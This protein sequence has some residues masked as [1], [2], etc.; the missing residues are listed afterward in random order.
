M[1]EIQRLEALRKTA[2]LDTAPEERFDRLTRLASTALGADIALVSFID[3]DRQ[4]FKSKQGTENQET[5]RD[6]A[7]CNHAIQSKD[8]MVVADA[9]K[10]SRFVNNPLVAGE[11]NIRF[12]AGAP[13]VTKDGHAL[14]TLC[15]LDDKPRADF[16]PK[17][18]QILADIAASVMTEIEADAQGQII[19]DLNVVNEELQHR[20]GNMYAHVSSLIS[21]MSRTGVEG[22]D[23]AE[24]LHE[25]IAILA[26][27]QALI[28]NNKFES[29]PLS[30]I[31]ESTIAPFL[32]DETRLRVQMSY[33]D[34][35]EVSAR[36][37]FTMTL[38][39]NELVTNALKHGAL[40][41]EEG[42][43]RFS[44]SADG[45]DIIKF[46]WKETAKL[47]YAGQ[48]EHKG[49][50]SQILARIVPMDLQGEADHAIREDGLNYTVTARRERIET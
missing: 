10:D 47:E 7:F 15:V 9:K 27:T 46:D 26:E 39:L 11:P 1:T 3:H 32:T 25:R 18:Q 48:S 20:M 8:V 6:I 43:I 17:Q 34:D 29:A 45:D 42:S 16:G 22:E 38:M 31:F 12:Y 24:R 4:W 2:L 5:P 37:A 23:F 21:M 14:G 33:S 41:G 49:F 36:G 28:A 40:K 50:G 13:L 44:W 35:I 19:D 30:D